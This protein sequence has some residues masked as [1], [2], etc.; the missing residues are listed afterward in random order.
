MN[1][2]SRLLFFYFFLFIAPIFCSAHPLDITYTTLV[3]EDN[4]LIGKTYIHPFELNQLANENSI[5]IQN[6]TEFPGLPTILFQ[7]FRN[8]FEVFSN[9]KKLA[10]REIQLEKKSLQEILA[11]GVYVFFKIP[12]S[13]IY[14]IKVS[15]FL[16]YS[17]TQSNKMILLDS[18][19]R[20]VSGRPEVIFT[21]KRQTWTLN[22][23]KPDFSADF[24]DLADADKDGL[25]DHLEYLF[26]TDSATVDTDCDGYSDFEEIYMG[27]DPLNRKFVKGQRAMYLKQMSQ[28]NS[29][30]KGMP[31]FSDSALYYKSNDPVVMVPTLNQNPALATDA[32]ADHSFSSLPLAQFISR[33]QRRIGGQFLQ[34]EFLLVLVF[35]FGLI[36]VFS[37]NIRQHKLFKPFSELTIPTVSSVFKFVMIHVSDVLGLSIV[38]LYLLQKFP[39]ADWFS[40]IQVFCWVGLLVIALVYSSNG[41][42]QLWRRRKQTIP[43][44]KKLPRWNGF[45]SHLD[46]QKPYSYRW[47]TFLFVI[48]L[49]KIEILLGAIGLFSLG[50]LIAFLLF[51]RSFQLN[52]HQEYDGLGYAAQ[53]LSHLMLLVMV[54]SVVVV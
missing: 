4:F 5:N 7:Y 16:E 12:K 22:F 37:Q 23:Q 53:I 34:S 44:E 45:F 13:K 15:L 26:G 39:Y 50:V 9:G 27:W 41:V 3:P 51:R 46:Y 2:Q 6:E 54:F 14:E 17:C 10:L 52:P 20:P 28:L 33:M 11:D 30:Y 1:I 18:E 29:S 8:K 19:A 32:N 36:H 35:L 49:G 43:Q 40:W 21:K 25:S 38:L 31:G 42:R 24:D 48:S 47:L